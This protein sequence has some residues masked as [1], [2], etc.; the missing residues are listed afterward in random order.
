MQFSIRQGYPKMF[1]FDRSNVFM[2]G[3]VFLNMPSEMG[4]PII[5]KKLIIENCKRNHVYKAKLH[6]TVENIKSIPV[7]GLFSR[8]ETSPFT[9]LKHWKG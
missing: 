7:L 8:L 2:P 1:V 6:V 3:E 5:A 4:I 9:Q